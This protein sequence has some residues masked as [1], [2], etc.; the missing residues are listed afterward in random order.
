M[1]ITTDELAVF[2][3]AV[4]TRSLSAAGKRLGQ[5]AS[6]TSRSLARLEEK[7]GATLLR[8]TTRQLQLTEEG[9]LFLERARAILDAIEAAEEAIA[10]RKGKPAGKLRIDAAAPFML[11]GIVPHVRAFAE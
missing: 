10:A 9:A 11:H 1:K 4:E 6:G 5:T 8:R 2:V 7:L 3:A